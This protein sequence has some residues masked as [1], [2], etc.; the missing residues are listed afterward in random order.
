MRWF[1]VLFVFICEIVS[2]DVFTKRSEFLG[3]ARLSLTVERHMNLQNKLIED[4]GQDKTTLGF[5]LNQYLDDRFYIKWGVIPHGIGCLVDSDDGNWASAEWYLGTV[6]SI[7][8][9]LV[10]PNF[11]SKAIRTISSN[12]AWWAKLNYG[13]TPGYETRYWAWRGSLQMGPRVKLAES[14]SLGYYG[15]ASTSET[16][17]A[18]LYDDKIHVKK[19]IPKR[20]YGV[21]TELNWQATPNWMLTSQYEVH[22]LTPT[23]EMPR[24]FRLAS[25]FLF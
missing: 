22:F 3:D 15:D 7:D 23:Q 16:A 1:G 11:E 6:S 9:F 21:V 8:G 5:G 13:V 12:V 4:V 17:I 25:T 20:L 2:A 10:V 19:E 24:V 18:F 14:L